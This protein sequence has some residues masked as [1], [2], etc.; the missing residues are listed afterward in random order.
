MLT[1]LRPDARREA[2]ELG[3][4][5]AEGQ[6]PRRK[7]IRLQP[8]VYAQAGQPFL[9]TLC[10]SRRRPIFAGTRYASLVF[11]E[12]LN[13]PVLSD[14]ECIAACLMPDHLHLLLISK[15][16]NLV[17]TIN[18][19][20]S[21]STNLLHAEGLRGPVWQRSFYDH[22]L[23]TEESVI[24]A[25]QY[26]VTNPVRKGLVEDWRSYPFAYLHPQYGR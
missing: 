18:A 16:R 11:R 12:L 4:G 7:P 14:A 24:E 15:K 8:E 13:G 1:Q 19:W 2:P 25:A 6:A 21:Y 10:T 23:R 26:V 5:E 17:H 3:R 9:F 20:K 22:A